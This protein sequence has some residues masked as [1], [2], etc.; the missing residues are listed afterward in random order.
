MAQAMPKSPDLQAPV[1]SPGRHDG[2]LSAQERDALA[3]GGFMSRLPAPLV[4]AILARV[5]VRRFAA[6]ERILRVGQSVDDWLGF[7][8]GGAQVFMQRPG[9]ADLQCTNWVAPGAWFNLYNPL[10]V[11]RSD[12][13]V[14]AEG[15]T[16]VASVNADDLAVLCARFPEFT[17]EL[18]V[19]NALNLRRALQ[20]VAASQHATLSQRQLLWLVECVRHVT[21][22]HVDGQ[23]LLPASFSQDALAQAHGVTRQAWSEGLKLLEHEGLIRRVAKG[24]LVPDIAGLETAMTAEVRG[25]EAPYAAQR[26]PEKPAVMPPGLSAA[27]ALRAAELAGVQAGRWFARLPAPLQQDILERGVVRRLAAGESLMRAGD[28]PAAC[29]LVVEGAILLDSSTGPAARCPVALLPPGSWYGHHDLVYDSSNLFDAVAFV[30]TTLVGLPAMDFHALFDQYLDFRL[31]LVRLL[32]DQ[33]SRATQQAV[34]FDWPI[35]TRIGVW[36]W[37]MHRGFDL[38]SAT[39][40][41]LAARFTLQDIAQWLGTTRQAVS[42]QLKVLEDQGIVR[43]GRD[44]LEVTRPRQLPGAASQELDT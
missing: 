14:R 31:M 10:A 25:I 35:E 41:R 18:A 6:G 28:R 1:P 2:P 42:R 38:A 13:E 22:Q 5:R 29:W 27:R 20:A 32:A 43:R 7:A 24:L 34:S 44:F 21:P 30:P 3:R 37:K 36:L 26:H 9:A 11:Q 17:R 4:D 33:Q 15:E 19:A 40:P 16:T 39:G 8:A 12:V 23:L